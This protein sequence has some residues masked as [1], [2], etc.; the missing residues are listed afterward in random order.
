MGGHLTGLR[1]LI[2][3]QHVELGADGAGDAGGAVG[4]LAIFRA[5]L[6]LGEERATSTCSR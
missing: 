6:G 4:R 2:G 3:P 5:R 1:R